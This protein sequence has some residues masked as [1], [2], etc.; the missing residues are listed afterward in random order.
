MYLMQSGKSE[1]QR[2][3]GARKTETL[4]AVLTE[5]DLGPWM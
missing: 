2:M 3:D 5:R 1:S 4:K